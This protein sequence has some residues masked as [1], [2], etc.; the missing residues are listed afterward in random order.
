MEGAELGHNHTDTMFRML[1]LANDA[2][3]FRIITLPL[4]VAH[5]SV[6]Q[7]NKC[8]TSGPARECAGRLLRGVPK[9]RLESVATGE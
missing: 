9:S 1:Y 4:D 6:K 7:T 3:E 8:R 2:Y 5:P